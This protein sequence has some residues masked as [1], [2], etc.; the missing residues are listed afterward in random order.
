[1][2]VLE[3]R[4]QGH[5]D[6]PVDDFDGLV[7]KTVGE[8]SVHD[9]LDLRDVQVLVGGILKVSHEIFIRREVHVRFQHLFKRNI[10]HLQYLLVVDLQ[11]LHQEGNIQRNMRTQQIGA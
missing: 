4:T 3:F 1:M 5:Y 6:G 8:F 2:L 10:G 9:L 11:L 7:G